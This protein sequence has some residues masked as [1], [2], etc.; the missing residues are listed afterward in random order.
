[1]QATAFAARI[2]KQQ[3]MTFLA[4]WLG[5]A[6]DGLDSVLYT[7]VAL[8]FV[9][10]LLHKAPKDPETLS[11]AAIIQAVFFV[12][13]AL[14]GFVFGRIGDKI[15][16]TKTLNLT[17]LT[18]ACFTGLSFISGEWW[19]LL[20]FRFIA[21]LGIGGEW[22]AGSAL[23]AETLPKR[24]H[25]W[26]SA[27]LQSGYM[28]GI[29]LASLTLNYLSAYPPKWVF[30]I[31]IIP[32]FATLWIRKAVPEPEEWSGA[33]EKQPAPP[34]SA[35]F[36]PKTLKTT[37]KVMTM[38]A[39]NL[40]G[41]WTII[42]FAAQLIRTH[43]ENAGMSPKQ[44][45]QLVAAVTAIYMVWNIA[46]NYFAAAVSKWLGYRKGLIV[47]L[48]ITLIAF[49]VGFGVPR[50]LS[51]TRLWISILG[52]TALGVFGIF[53]LYFP[54]L[55][56]TLL[57]TTGAGFCYNMGRLITAGTTF[58]ASMLHD[59]RTAI[60][61]SGFLYIFA[62]LLAFTMPEPKHHEPDALDPA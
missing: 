37:L 17:I 60:F 13:W 1:V 49:L 46:G 15:G 6:F 39:I 4:A 30:L 48:T 34:I 55:F 9:G 11:K 62:I 14:G 56:P 8:P 53:P 29:L 27:T 7:L 22:A 25:H 45:A 2:T 61:Y 5:W 52:F 26:A 20:I 23:V 31:G 42:F 3:G 32:A 38:S 59:A 47:L 21:A 43:P 58:V 28:I 54:P 57:R 10:E 16:R 33:K 50:S 12:G 40:C 41:A 35:L 19:H 18:Y 36:G 44:L 24:F 51:D